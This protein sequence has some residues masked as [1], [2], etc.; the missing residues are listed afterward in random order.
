MAYF[1]DS[2][3]NGKGL[4]LGPV[5]ESCKPIV[6]GIDFGTA[7]SGV[8]FVFKS[9]PSSI[10]CGAPTALEVVQT[11]VPTAILELSDGTCEFGYAA[12]ANSRPI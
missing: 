9:D 4:L 7:Y 11:K 8:A 12:E 3:Q 10:T 6:V 5:S 2:V 1:E